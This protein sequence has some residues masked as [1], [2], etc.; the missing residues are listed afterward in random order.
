MNVVPPTITADK[1]CHIEISKHWDAVSAIISFSQIAKSFILLARWLI[2][3]SLLTMA[4]FGF[5]VE[6]DVKIV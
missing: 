4:P 2:N 5:P 1:N 3:P 6:P